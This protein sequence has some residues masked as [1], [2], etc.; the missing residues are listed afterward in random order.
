MRGRGSLGDLAFCGKYRSRFEIIASILKAAKNN[1]ASLFS[2]R[3]QVG[4]NHKQIKKYLEYLIKIGL[5]NMDVRDGQVLYR[6]SKRGL[7]FLRHYNILGEILLNRPVE[8]HFV[9]ATTSSLRLE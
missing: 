6:T 3:N 2:L 8:S 9:L 5:V 7:T 4:T 1:G